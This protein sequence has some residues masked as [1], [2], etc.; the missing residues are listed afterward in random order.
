[1]KFRLLNKEERLAV[2]ED[3][4]HFLITNGVSNEEWIALNQKNDP[5]ATE[6]VA[7]FSDTVFQKV[8]EKIAVAELRSKANLMVFHFGKK[9]IEL[10]GI[11]A[12]VDAVNIDF[13]TTES[14]H[15][16]LLNH[17]S[18]LKFFKQTKVY[19]K[20]RELEVFEMIEKGCLPSH[21]DFWNTLK[22]ATAE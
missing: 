14:I 4:K 8:M 9:E 3:F 16:A 6:L 13:S 15:Q 2:D 18:E 20:D 5:K 21:I 22:K 11:H 12:D 19:E 7:V 17:A 1:M 10:I